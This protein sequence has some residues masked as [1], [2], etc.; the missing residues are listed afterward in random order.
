ME[1]L[2]NERKGNDLIVLSSAPRDMSLERIQYGF[3]TNTE[4]DDARKRK[5]QLLTVEYKIWIL[6]GYCKDTTHHQ[7]LNC[8]ETIAT[9]SSSSTSQ[10][11][12]PQ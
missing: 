5:H 3:K 7:S 1:E 6:R 2:S 9:L 10:S 12:P 11:P 4:P 8:L